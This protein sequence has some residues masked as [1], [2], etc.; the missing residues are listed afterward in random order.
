MALI[1]P[2]LID[3]LYDDRY[4]EAG[5]IIVMISCAQ[6]LSVIMLTYDQAALARG[7]SRCFFRVV[8]IRAV[9][10]TGCFVAGAA[11]LDCPARCLGQAVAAVLVYPAVA[12]LA[13]IPG[14][15]TS[16]TTRFSRVA[17]VPIIDG[18]CRCTG[19]RSHRFC[20]DAYEVVTIPGLHLMSNP[21]KRSN[22]SVPCPSRQTRPGL[23]PVAALCFRRGR[24][25]LV[26]AW[27]ALGP[28]RG[29]PVRPR[30]A[31]RRAQA[32]RAAG[33]AAR[34]GLAGNR[35]PTGTVGCAPG[36]GR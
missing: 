33:R 32:C 25:V 7:D 30:R 14:S 11:L 1:G 29:A 35:A 8:A 18:A 5:P 17:V 36:P 10:Q 6:M 27:P 4:A 21:Q 23:R 16:A 20:P 26:F 9:V 15:G 28:G 19:T 22:R 31:D 24:A 3:F 34:R 2:W 13:A 12:A